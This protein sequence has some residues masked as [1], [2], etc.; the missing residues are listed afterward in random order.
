MF[1]EITSSGAKFESYTESPLN[2]FICCYLDDYSESI[3]SLS[4]LP[5]DSMLLDFATSIL[6]SIGVCILL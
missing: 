4:K 6:F 2:L 5:N 3:K 1:R